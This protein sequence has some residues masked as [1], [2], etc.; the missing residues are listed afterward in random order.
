M[1]T[2]KL[3]RRDSR[4]GQV[5]GDSLARHA[6]RHGYEGAGPAAVHI[7]ESHDVAQRPLPRGER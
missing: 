2:A 1:N 7:T 6:E 4:V 5:L 3:T